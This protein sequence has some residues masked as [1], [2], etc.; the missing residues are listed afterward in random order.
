MKRIPFSE[1]RKC[2]VQNCH[3][4]ISGITLQPVGSM[5]PLELVKQPAGFPVLRSEKSGEIKKTGKE[6][7]RSWNRSL[8]EFIPN[9]AKTNFDGMLSVFSELWNRGK[10]DSSEN[11]F[12]VI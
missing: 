6:R 5:L 2:P 3:E 1:Q 12:P 9:F 4:I 7:G 10:T 11:C 8:P